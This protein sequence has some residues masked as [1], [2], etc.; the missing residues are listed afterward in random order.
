[1]L[2]AN[3]KHYY[4]FTKLYEKTITFSLRNLKIRKVIYDKEQSP[5]KEPSRLVN[6]RRASKMNFDLNELKTQI[7]KLERYKPFVLYRCSKISALLS[8]NISPTVRS[9]S[10]L[11]TSTPDKKVL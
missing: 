1:M 9:I 7:V 8:S 4:I 6:K 3:Y 10:S 11:E 2:A 5:P